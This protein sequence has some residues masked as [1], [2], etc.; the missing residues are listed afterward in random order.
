MCA[1][2][3]LTDTLARPGRDGPGPHP[4]TLPRGLARHAHGSTGWWQGTVARTVVHLAKLL[5]REEQP[6]VRVV[7]L[8]LSPRDA[9]PGRR[10]SASL[11][12]QWAVA[13]ESV[14]LAVCARSGLC[15]ARGGWCVLGGGGG[16][17]LTSV[18]ALV[19]FL[20]QVHA[21]ARACLV[22]CT[23]S[24]A[25]ADPAS[26]PLSLPCTVGP[27][28][29]EWYR[30]LVVVGSPSE[31]YCW[32][33]PGGSPQ[34]IATGGTGQ[35]DAVNQLLVR[36]TGLKEAR[37]LC[38]LRAACCVVAGREHHVSCDANLST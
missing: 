16:V 9:W 33:K 11:H 32:Y 13:L 30:A 38:V 19:R 15:R 35:P 36:N 3:R 27:G 4:V 34:G 24:G 28:G 31:G 6:A 37:C 1:L 25:T 10:P 5:E 17:A 2:S 26:V 20:P 8:P 23:A 21:N 29:D 7:C 18:F 22:D 12:P 14:C